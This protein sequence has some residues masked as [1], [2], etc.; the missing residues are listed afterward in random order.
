MVS[1]VVFVVPFLTI[2]I[3]GLTPHHDVGHNQFWTGE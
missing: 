2:S 3:D 1:R